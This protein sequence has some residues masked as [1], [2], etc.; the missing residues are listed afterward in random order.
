[1]TTNAVDSSFVHPRVLKL[2]RR[3]EQLAGSGDPETLGALGNED[4]APSFRAVA[5][6]VPAGALLPLA[7]LGDCLRVAKEAIDAD[8]RRSPAE[9]RYVRRLVGDAARYFR[10]AR[11]S[12]A[13]PE[14]AHVAGFL[15]MHANDGQAFGGAAKATAWIGLD[16]C[17]GVGDRELLR[18]YEALLVR[19]LD[20]IVHLEGA[21][22]EEEAVRERLAALI[23][24]RR[25]MPS[26]PPARA[27]SH[28][29]RLSAFLRSGGPQVFA[30]TAY[31]NQVF[32]PDP[33]DVESIHDHAREVF[34]RLLERAAEGS[35][36][37]G[38]MLLIKGESGAGKTHLMRAFRTHAHRAGLGHVG[39]MQMSSAHGDYGVYALRKTLD[40]LEHPHAPP[41]LEVSS[42]RAL[43]DAL[44]ARLPEGAQGRLDAPDDAREASFVAAGLADELLRTGCFE[45]FDPDFLRAMLLLQRDDP[46]QRARVL[47]YLRC[48]PLGGWDQRV[49]G[50]IAVG[51][52]G[53]DAQRRL[54]SL[55]RLVRATGQGALV[56]LVDQLEDVFNLEQAPQ[57]FLR[58]LDVL[59]ALVSAE[60]NAIV[61]VSCLEQFYVHVAQHLSR[62]SRDRLEHDPEPVR[63]TGVR[64]ADE[65]EQLLG[66]RLAALYDQ[67][68]VEWRDDEPLYPL[69]REWVAQLAQLRTRDV[70]ENARRYQERCI[71]AGAIVSDTPSPGPGPEPKADDRDFATEWSDALGESV[72]LPG[73]EE[74]LAALLAECAP[75][76]GDELGLSV[77]ARAEGR[78]VQLRVG[79]AAPLDVGV[80]NR[81]TRGGGLKRQL[82]EHAKRTAP[83][84]MVIVR[85][86]DFRMGARALVAKRLGE[87]IGQG[88][89]RFALP[90]TDWRSMAAYGAFAASRVQEEGF[91]RWRREARVLSALPLFEA[92]FEGA[93]SANEAAPP[94]EKA[95]PE[96]SASPP[97]P[98]PVR[99]SAT[100]APESSAGS[101]PAPEGALRIG[102]QQGLRSQPVELDPEMLKRHS[103]FLGSPGSGKTT[104]AL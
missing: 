47:K 57:R 27:R 8:G 69:P 40:S 76:A 89:R 64:R 15:D 77:R 52:D 50:D 58:A 36:G 91:A 54:A 22:P 11:E 67:L 90:E 28:D 23:Q 32:L 62:A 13:G 102:R 78:F 12:Y 100:P 29:E 26:L 24:R 7:L 93:S 31:L 35:A 83:E 17:G 48:E 49:L 71:A 45:G 19:L 10:Q 46:P 79:G 5:A 53:G 37:T 38:R 65:V 1:M 66:T 51:G 75:R 60:P 74:G 85:S 63:L 73:D 70:I 99:P 3:I 25:A 92:L 16:L 97:E 104:L 18:D 21:S 2:S 103:A 14:A 61:V 101:T 95:A 4:A 43:S 55:A 84:R 9:L 56:L 20:E 33:H 30:G 86:G 72:A 87:L 41:E 98:V 6:T 81:G 68:D 44:M 88:A 39:Y 42:L 96:P 34:G 94:P 82:D 59:R 80:A